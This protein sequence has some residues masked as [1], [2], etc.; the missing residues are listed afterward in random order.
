MA[1]IAIIGNGI[2]GITAARHIRKLSGSRIT[3]ISGESDHFYSR[4]ALMY[5]YMGHMKYE[6]TKPYEDFF[7][8]KN[9][10]DLLRAS[11]T[12]IDTDAKVL[13]L[14]GKPDLA[15]DKLIV[16]TGSKPNKFGWPGQ[17]LK[18][19]HGF[20][21]L[22]DLEDIERSTKQISRA[23]IAGGGLIGIELA[24]MLASR[25]IP[26][27]FLVREKN[28]WDNVLPEEESKMI[29]RHILE[30]GIDLRL[31]SEL[32]EIL[33]D[34]NGRARAVVTKSGEEIACQF[35]GL[36][37]GVSPN[38]DV[39]KSSKIATKRGVLVSEFLETNVPDVYAAGD[40][41][42]L[43]GTDGKSHVEQLWYTGRMQAEALAQ[44]ICGTRTKYERGILFNSAKFLDIEYQTYG[45]VPNVLHSSD[46]TLYWEH[47]DG[48]HSIRLVYNAADDAIT[49]FNLFGIRYRQA[50][51]ERWIKERRTLQ[52][53]LEHLGEANFDP[54]FFKQYESEIVA[55]YNR[56]HPE[57]PLAL[58]AKRGLFSTLQ[59]RY[60]F[61]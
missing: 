18:G 34:D 13:K 43:V 15:Y 50:V 56:Q 51:C 17:D 19:V 47:A 14:E 22:Q 39:V 31:Q 57:K 8:A 25:K 32:K 16:A 6:H 49:G 61:R 53:V 35:V 55:L 45:S 41:A 48:H 24:E 44:T 7:W 4:T 36:T 9:Q 59:F 60:Q 58:K 12:A 21:G 38:L 28:Y 26:V 11:V 1:H 37:A 10:I 42:E 40:C 2:T 27:T 46:R 5:I 3:V 20:Y 52:Y 30:H 54:E 23:V 29:S 33:A